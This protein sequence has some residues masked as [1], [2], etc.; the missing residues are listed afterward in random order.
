MPVIG[1]P[2]ARETELK[3]KEEINLILPKYNWE[4]KPKT[5]VCL[6]FLA[7]EVPPV[8]ALT[9][10]KCTPA[11]PFKA[12]TEF[13]SSVPARQKKSFFLHSAGRVGAE[14]QQEPN[15]EA[16]SPLPLPLQSGRALVATFS[17]VKGD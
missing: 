3:E 12:Q 15:S 8:K 16:G 10:C 14:N 2:A 5:T 4:W 7:I 11:N 17:F 13:H 6:L 1:F 9:A